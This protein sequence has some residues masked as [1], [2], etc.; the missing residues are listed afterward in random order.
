MIQLLN[1][2]SSPKYAEYIKRLNNRTRDVKFLTRNKNID[3]LLANE[4]IY[5]V[6]LRCVIGLM[7]RA[8]DVCDED[9][10]EK[11]LKDFTSRFD[12]ILKK[13]HEKK[14]I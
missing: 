11:I 4:F 12:E 9:P 14:G 5:E 7:D 2:V 1:F 8:N 3:I 13:Y 6:Y 10:A